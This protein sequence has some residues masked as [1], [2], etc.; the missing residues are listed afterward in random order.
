MAL[1]FS[2]Q[3]SDLMILLSSPSCH[4]VAGCAVVDKGLQKN[5]MA[6][7]RLLVSQRLLFHF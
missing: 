5:L 7:T 1:V 4:L 6:K 2:S 3:T